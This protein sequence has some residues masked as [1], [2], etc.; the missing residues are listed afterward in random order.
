[1]NEAAR[2]ALEQ[3]EAERG[4]LT[5]EDVVAAARPADSPLHDYFEWRE[6]QAAAKYRLEQARR[7]IQRYRVEFISPK[8]IT[9][10]VRGYASVKRTDDGGERR[11][12]VSVRTALADEDLHSQ[13]LADLRRD[14]NALRR[15]YAHLEE[16]AEILLEAIAAD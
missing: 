16:F 12:F 7:V 1:M 11:V 2:K 3:I 10:S 4:E 6:T 13:I 9:R 8:Q 14:V 5:T 15:K